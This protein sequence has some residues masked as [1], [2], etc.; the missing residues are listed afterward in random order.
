MKFKSLMVVHLALLFGSAQAGS[1][2]LITPI[3]TPNAAYFEALDLNNVGQVAGSVRTND[4]VWHAVR[5][6]NNGMATYLDIPGGGATGASGINDAGQIA[7]YAY[8]GQK[9]SAIVWTGNV[10]QTLDAPAIGGAIAVDINDLGDVGG[11]TPDGRNLITWSQGGM[12]LSPGQIGYAVVRAINNSGQAVGDLITSVATPAVWNNGA[13]TQLPY[14]GRYAWVN[15]INDRGQMIGSGELH[16][17]YFWNEAG[18]LILGPENSAASGINNLGQ[19]VGSINGRPILWGNGVGGEAQDIS[20]LLDAQGWTLTTAGKINDLG[21]ILGYAT[22]QGVSYHVLLSPV[23]ELGS[24]FMMLLGIVGLAA[25][26][27]R[28]R[29]T[30]GL[31]SMVSLMNMAK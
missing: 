20:G 18:E 13:L 16:Q 11:Y 30:K 7:G 9:F 6:D 25:G 10:A 8:D 2:Y 15:D 12:S 24:G 1:Q 19:V 29:N 5:W 28:R 21:Q 22:Y 3:S 14:A 23:P 27:R 4:G 26:V 31:G 17:A